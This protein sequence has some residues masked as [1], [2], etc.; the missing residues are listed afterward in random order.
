MR[1]GR[2]GSAS[3]AVQ[4]P[5]GRPSA[6]AVPGPRNSPIRRTMPS[7]P[8]A[9]ANGKTEARQAR[10]GHVPVGQD[11]DRGLGGG[12]GS[13]QITRAGAARSVCKAICRSVIRSRTSCAWVNSSFLNVRFK[14]SPLT[15]SISVNDLLQLHGIARSSGFPRR[16]HASR[17][18]LR[19]CASSSRRCGKPWRPGCRFVCRAGKTRLRFGSAPPTSSSALRDSSR[20][21]RF[22]SLQ[23]T[24]KGSCLPRLDFR[25]DH[26]E[27]SSLGSPAATPTA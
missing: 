26:L 18:S 14:F 17:R 22:P 5:P 1:R 2:R 27:A 12:A 6:V 7:Q 16:F 20:R 21:S 19:S 10:H 15:C 4:S 3:A 11:L 23:L 24:Y 9:S 25:L 13:C 8:T